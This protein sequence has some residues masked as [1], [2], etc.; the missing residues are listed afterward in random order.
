MDS[1]LNTVVQDLLNRFDN[2]L[3]DVLIIMP[4][5]RPK[6]FF[7][8]II[9]KL[10]DEPII[11]PK[12]L[13]I[14]EFIE[15]EG[16]RHII[17]T[18]PAI[19]ELYEIYKANTLGN[20]PIERFW[21]F[22][23]M[24][25]S[26]FDDLD[27]YLADVQK[28]F[29]YVHDL[30]EIE[31]LFDDA[32][33]DQIKLIKQFWSTVYVENDGDKNHI[34][35]QFLL[36]WKILYPLYTDFKNRLSEQGM[37]YEGMLYR[38]VAQKAQ[39][40]LLSFDRKIP[41]FIG[42]NALS[43]SEIEIFEAA[44]RKNA[45]FYW[46][47]DTWYTK[48]SV[49]EA[50]HFMRVNLARFPSAIDDEA[51]FSNIAKISENQVRLIAMP[52][53]LEMTTSA[54]R[55]LT[56]TGASDSDPM[57]IAVVTANESL[58]TPL[59]D[60]I[61]KDLGLFNVTMGLPVSNTSVFSFI[62]ELIL[63]NKNRIHHASEVFYK[64]DWVISVLRQPI[65]IASVDDELERIKSENSPNIKASKYIGDAWFAALFPTE[66]LPLISYLKN[67]LN[68]YI[69]HCATTS[70]NDETLPDGEINVEAAV[71]IFKALSQLEMQ[72]VR[73]N[74]V[75][76]D[77]LVVRLLHKVMS[78]LKVTLEGEPLRGKQ[79]MGLIET[80]SLDFEHVI[81]VGANEGFV[82]K[83][84][85][86]PSFIPYNI[87]KAYGLLTYEH[88]DAIFAYY[89]YRLIQRSQTITF[90]YNNN[91]N[92]ADY[93][94][95]SRFVQ[96]LMF[97]RN[98]QQKP[99]VG[100]HKLMSIETDKITIAKTESMLQKLI[101]T[102]G[103]ADARFFPVALNS[104]LTCRLKFYF[105]YIARIKTPEP[106]SNQIDQRV[107]GNIFH[108][109]MENLYNPYQNQLITPELIAVIGKKD[110]VL[111]EIRKQID[112]RF[113]D[114]SAGINSNGLLNIVEQVVFK[115]VK[116][117][118]ENDAKTGAFVLKS[119]EDTSTTSIQIDGKSVTLAGKIDR[120]Q[121]VGS[122]IFV[123]DY[124]TGKPPTTGIKFDDMFEYGLYKRPS[125]PF[126]AMYYA[127][128][129][130]KQMFEQTREVVPA[131]LY[132]QERK[133]LDPLKFSDKKNADVARLNNDFEAHLVPLLRE[134]LNVDVPFDQT[135]DARNCINCEFNVICA[136][137]ANND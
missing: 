5:K 77:V 72:F 81:L 37:G 31:Q 106:Y 35:K 48:N 61:P 121:E 9:G 85:V 33:D 126:Q 109:T 11:A 17:E 13:T 24:L 36:F 96:Q 7:N 103:D 50:G 74:V 65:H 23:E 6:V 15:M 136:R 27:K 128:I 133:Q 127:Y 38:D 43:K 67:I 20:E 114:F 52:G 66:N 105:K 79:V 18:I 29:T 84:G 112:A 123:I 56:A 25:L 63:I 46:D 68:Q 113:K 80:R 82:P 122:Q 40:D 2:R 70:E 120:M 69:R 51:Y 8:H 110:V 115:Y 130:Q 101:P 42:F 44:K 137:N 99:L 34:R 47:Y 73:Y 64:A 19:T 93:G 116:K 102:S 71:A 86:A 57:K 16:G 28:V 87:R 54:A 107:F 91:E 32:D 108:D 26:D 104:Y 41:V 30:K 83:S 3:E 4:G 117:V 118:L 78:G 62:N 124:K 12:M 92:D 10:V 94:E 135:P 95:L 90:I 129:V 131:L 88:Q 97:E 76:P 75:L 1:F 60:T 45:L 132:I 111:R 22:G 58:L 125:S 89:F 119:V 98:F 14:N 100:T 59:L 55:E 49:Q 39:H 21:H 134:I 53:E